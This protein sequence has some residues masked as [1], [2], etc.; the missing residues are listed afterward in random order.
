MQ[1]WLEHAQLSTLAIYTNAIGGEE[2][3]GTA[4]GMT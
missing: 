1:R 4:I 3:G 2:H